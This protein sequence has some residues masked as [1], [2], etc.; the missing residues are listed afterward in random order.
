MMLMLSFILQ[1]QAT[2][3]SEQLFLLLCFNTLITVVIQQLKNTNDLEFRQICLTPPPNLAKV[4]ADFLLHRAKA[5]K[6]PIVVNETNQH[7]VLG[8]SC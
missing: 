4:G 3:L 7:Q 2:T 5:L 1:D 8:A 6:G